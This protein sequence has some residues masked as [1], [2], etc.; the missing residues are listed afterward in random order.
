MNINSSFTIIETDGGGVL[1]LKI[2]LQ[3]QILKCRINGMLELSF[4]IQ[5]AFKCEFKIEFN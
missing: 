5:F 3:P 1:H 2:C 4:D